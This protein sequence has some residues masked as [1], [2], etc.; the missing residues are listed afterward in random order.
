MIKKDFDL[1]T[2]KMKTKIFSLLGRGIVKLINAGAGTQTVQLVGL[3]GENL[4]DIERME[5]YGFT[6]YPEEDS[7]AVIASLNGN[8]DE[9]V[10]LCINDRRYRPK[11]LGKGDVVVYN[12]TGSKITLKDNGDVEIESV[13][14][15][16][17]NSGD[18]GAWKPCIIGNC[19]FTGAPHGGVPAAI[20]K[21]KGK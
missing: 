21:L 10:V 3:A 12:K 7:E 9:S 4:T 14:D 18:A 8:R 2:A 6:S 20:L 13:K 5:E 16:V 1:L 15:I 17:L 11:D 19:I